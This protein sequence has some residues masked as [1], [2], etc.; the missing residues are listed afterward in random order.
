M[1]YLEE[2]TI[3]SQQNLFKNIFNNNVSWFINNLVE[4]AVLRKMQINHVWRSLTLLIVSRYWKSHYSILWRFST[5]ILKNY[6]SKY[7]LR[8]NRLQ[9]KVNIIVNFFLF[10]QIEWSENKSFHVSNFMYNHLS[11]VIKVKVLNTFMK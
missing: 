8:V 7:V 2:K 10:S 3:S 5:Y 11:F 9:G 1:P 6:P 4:F